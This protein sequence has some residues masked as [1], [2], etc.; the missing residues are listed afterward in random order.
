M[1]HSSDRS[2]PVQSYG[3]TGDERKLVACVLSGRGEEVLGSSTRE[4]RD[5]VAVTVRL[6]RPPSWYFHDLAGISLPV[7][8]SLHDPLATP[9]VLDYR[10]GPTRVEMSRTERT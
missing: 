9:H 2:G 1:P 3:R 10:T 4:E 8:V 5:T 6:R 7:V